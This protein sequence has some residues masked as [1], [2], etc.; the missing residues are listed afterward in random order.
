[1]WRN[2]PSLLDIAVKEVSVMSNLV[3]LLL[4]FLHENALELEF[5]IPMVQ[6]LWH[7]LREGM[8]QGPVA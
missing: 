4:Y 1:M 2:I 5:A 3:S 6:I 7:G 8:H